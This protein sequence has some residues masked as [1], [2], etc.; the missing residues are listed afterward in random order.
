MSI[1]GNPASFNGLLIDNTKD[2]YAVI[3]TT[4]PEGSVCTASN[5]GTIL[6][7]SDTSGKYI[8]GLPNGGNWT[9]SCTD[10]TKSNSEVIEVSKGMVAEAQLFYF[11]TP[12]DILDNYSWEDISKISQAGVGDEYFD[13]GDCKAVALNG[14]V[15]TLTLD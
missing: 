4:Y 7:A 2:V 11:P 8:F 3:I 10:G 9:V 5:N 13:I 15:G 14:T 6:T 1:L 12:G